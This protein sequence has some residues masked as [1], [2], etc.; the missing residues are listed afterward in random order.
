MKDI[1]NSPRG[2]SRSNTPNFQK[3]HSFQKPSYSFDQSKC[4][5]FN[6]SFVCE[7]CTTRCSKWAPRAGTAGFR[8]PE[9]LFRSTHQ[10][11][12]LDIWSAGIILLCILSGRYP[13]FKAADDNMAIMQLISLFG[14]EA[15]RKSAFKY[16]ESLVCSHDKKAISLKEICTSLR[17]N[18]IKNLQNKKTNNK[19]ST[20]TIEDKENESG[21][22][23]PDDIYDLLKKLLELD[24][25][26][27]LSA[28]DALKHSFFQNC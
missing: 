15:V 21:D 24:S 23:F 9:V 5:C 14:T 2:N 6:M 12:A 11:Q 13:F 7:N 20:T 3:F 18:T 25:E 26:K 27:R 10:T 16:G 8:A 4:T 19:S 22:I 1:L 17:R 28:E